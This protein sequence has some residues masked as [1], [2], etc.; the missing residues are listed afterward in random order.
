MAKKA[1][2]QGN[3]SMENAKHVREFMKLSTL[4]H[5]LQFLDRLHEEGLCLPLSLVRDLTRIDLEE[6]LKKSLLDV[7]DN[8]DS[9]ALE[10]YLTRGIL[11]WQQNLASHAIGVW[12]ERT[13]RL[14]WYRLLPLASNTETPQR[15]AYTLI[16][17]AKDIGGEAL[18]R[19]FLCKDL[20][21][22]RSGAFLAMLIERAMAWDIC[23]A[24]LLSLCAPLSMTA[25]HGDDKAALAKFFY[26]LD[27]DKEKLADWGWRS[28]RFDTAADLVRK[29][30]SKTEIPKKNGLAVL[31]QKGARKE[32]AD[33]ALAM[34]ED[35][36]PPV[37]E[38][39]SI[40]EVTLVQA[41]RA[42]H[43]AQQERCDQDRWQ[44]FGG[45]GSTKLAGALLTI[46]DGAVIASSL[47]LLGH[48][49]S[50]KD[51]R[52]IVTELAARMKKGTLAGPSD[53]FLQRL[54]TAYRMALGAGDDGQAKIH[55][56]IAAE[57]E[58]F[59]GFNKA[60]GDLPFCLS[61]P[62]ESRL[63][64]GHEANEAAARTP[65]FAC[66]YEKKEVGIP[67][68]ND[69]SLWKLMQRAY[70]TADESLLHEL[71]LRARKAP[72][73]WHFCYIDTLGRYKGSD[74][75]VL[76]LLDYIRS[77]DEMLLNTVAHALSGIG[78]KR[79]LLELVAFLTRP[80][81]K[82]ALKHEI[83][84]ILRR[85]DLTGLQAE[86]RSAI[87]DL[88][89]D[90]HLGGLDRD[91]YDALESLIAANF[92]TVSHISKDQHE[93]IGTEELDKLLSQKLF[94]FPRLSSEVKRSMRTAQFFHMLVEKSENMTTIDLSPAIDMQ[95][96]AL[97]LLFRETFEH[98]VS[99]ML[100]VGLLQRKLDLLGYARP[101]TSK[102]DE[103]ENF[104]QNLPII[105]TIPFFSKFK[106]R[107]MLQ[108]ICQFRRGK[109]FTLD[110]LKAF[111]LFFL[112]FS[113]K[114]CRFG[115]HDLFAIP[116][117]SD[118]QLFTFVKELHMFQDFRNR[119]AHEGFHPD[120]SNDLDGLWNYTVK[121]VLTVER[122]RETLDALPMRQVS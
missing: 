38:R 13:D 121:I 51:Q 56:Q 60:N 92:T 81:I 44:L 77:D 29:L 3:Q 58:A 95:Y 117:I 39:K 106:L 52:M 26:L 28:G 41:Y 76:K 114:D 4:G 112:C 43:A 49:V 61:I 83:I 122:I 9:L 109:R 101:I 91:L 11:S 99:E 31:S 74:Q 10:E 89:A 14:L 23:D 53:D 59:G 110:G 102:M 113:R 19:R 16:Q 25:L 40:D 62:E 104:I 85:F 50:A 78:T 45:I 88:S 36:W 15:V 65:F 119:A 71:A 70:V 48:L 68:D 24:E 86:L 108:G 22:D 46:D 5:R 55:T 69:S 17:F 12:A 94:C 100:G 7:V 93:D 1:F 66:A 33:V 84:Q 115:L 75:A 67:L 2:L 32:S 35:S 103:F 97:E 47:Q 116:N 6:S 96:K 18:I 27:F 79:A 111:G 72:P 8:G 80:N 87:H 57:M 118:E 34:L 105:T 64:G 37:W 107:K 73:L 90:T 82:H 54:S 120:K 42:V 30:S 98:A 20:L 63:E 21:S